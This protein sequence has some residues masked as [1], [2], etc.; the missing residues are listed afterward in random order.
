[1]QINGQK[2]FFFLQKFAYFKIKLY[3]CIRF[4]S[5]EAR[6]TEFVRQI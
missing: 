3:L 6:L 1:M 4:S 2:T 5:E